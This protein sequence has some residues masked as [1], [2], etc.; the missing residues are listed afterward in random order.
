MKTGVEMHE[1]LDKKFVG[2]KDTRRV[3]VLTGSRDARYLAEV[4]GQL[5]HYFDWGARNQ[6]TVRLAIAILDEIGASEPM[7]IRYHQKLA[8]FLGKLPKDEALIITEAQVLEN[9]GCK[10]VDGLQEVG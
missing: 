3:V 6:R 5:T 10:A 4:P 1:S 8:G 7:V 9:L 2:H